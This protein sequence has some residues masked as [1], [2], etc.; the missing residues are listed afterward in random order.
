[1]DD[2]SASRRPARLPERYQ[3]RCSS[4]LADAIRAAAEREEATPSELV[5]RIVRER[6]VGPATTELRSGG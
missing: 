2:R 3:F 5:R 1:M 6:L 4:R